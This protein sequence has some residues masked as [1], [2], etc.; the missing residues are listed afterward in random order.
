MRR[1]TRCES[2]RAL[3]D[4]AD[5]FVNLDRQ[6]PKSEHASRRHAAVIHKAV[7]RP[8]AD[9]GQAAGETRQEKAGG[10]DRDILQI[11][12]ILPARPACSLSGQ[13]RVGGEER[14]EHDDVAE[15]EDPEAVADYDSLRGRIR[16][17]ENGYGGAPSLLGPAVAVARAGLKGGHDTASAASASPRARRLARS[18]R[19]T[20][21]AG[22][23]YSVRSRQ[24]KTTNVAKAPTRASD[25]QPPDMPDHAEA[26]EGGEERAD[27]TG[28]AVSRHLDGPVDRFDHRTRPALSKPLLC[29][30][31]RPG[32][33]PEA[34]RRS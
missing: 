27:E 9:G 20:S 32:P 13:H 15:Q 33:R 7:V 21:S 5:E 2:A 24:A 14:R 16:V 17:I 10:L 3:I 31:S 4:H 6:E 30:N 12:Q 26:A 22:I 23:S 11:E 18:M 34:G 8:G 19:A 25:D 1:G 29:A 28:R